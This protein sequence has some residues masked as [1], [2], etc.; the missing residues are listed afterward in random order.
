MYNFLHNKY[1]VLN[2]HSHIRRPINES[3]TVGLSSYKQSYVFYSEKHTTKAPFQG[4][5][6]QSQAL[7][8]FRYQ[9]RDS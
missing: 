5:F 8:F 4:S 6:E 1:V 7:S 9:I 3:T 2:V